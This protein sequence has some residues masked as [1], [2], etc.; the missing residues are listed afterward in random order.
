MYYDAPNRLSLR[1]RERGSNFG[2]FMRNAIYVPIKRRYVD[3]CIDEICTITYTTI[4]IPDVL[5]GV[6]KRWRDRINLFSMLQRKRLREPRLLRRIYDGDS[7]QH[8]NLRLRKHALRG[9]TRAV[10]AAR[11]ARRGCAGKY[12]YIFKYWKSPAPGQVYFQAVKVMSNDR[13]RTFLGR[14]LR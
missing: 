14:V 1:E 11:R 13:N 9:T 5:F 12:G 4:T 10:S 8:K 6:R 2:R 7:H 3:V